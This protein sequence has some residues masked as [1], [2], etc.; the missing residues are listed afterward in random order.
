MKKLFLA[1]LL[2]VLLPSAI[3]AQ[4]VPAPA[5][6]GY[7]SY[8]KVFKAMDGY[9]IVRHNIDQLRNQY[10]A[11]AKRSEEDFN[12]KYEA[13]LDEQAGLASNIRKKRQA[14]IMDL[15]EKNSAFKKEAEKLISDAEN[16]ATDSL[17]RLI[18]NAA[19][20]VGQEH[21]L[22]FVFNTDNHSV[23][24]VNP[25]YCDDITTAIEEKLAKK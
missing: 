20:E 19:R 22:A 12:T 10:T 14:E 6:Y 21:G 16:S 8:K 3:C 11:E 9:S 24:F 18:D 13:F 23:P 25:Q 17:C 15:M 7:F 1:L 2:A 4:T 5:R